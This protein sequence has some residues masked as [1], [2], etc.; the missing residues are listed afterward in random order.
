M[1][2]GLISEL[3]QGLCVVHRTMWG[4]PSLGP[5]DTPETGGEQMQGCGGGAWGKEVQI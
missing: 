3:E 1:Q 2:K 4:G 5:G